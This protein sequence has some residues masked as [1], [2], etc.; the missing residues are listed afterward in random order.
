MEDEIKSN[1][2]DNI[3]DHLNKKMQTLQHKYA[4]IVGEIIEKDNFLK[5]HL[6]G[7]AESE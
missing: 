6:L 2:Q 7:R 3:I 5:Q 1:E 4:S